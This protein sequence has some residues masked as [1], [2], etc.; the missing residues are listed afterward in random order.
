MLTCVNKNSKEFRDLKEMSGLSEFYIEAYS[1]NYL[2]KLDRFPYLDEIPNAN[3]EPYLQEKLKMKGRFGSVSELLKYTGTSSV[4]DAVIVINN[5]HR[6]LEVRAIQISEDSVIIN[7]DHKPGKYSKDFQ[8]QEKIENNHSSI[9]LD[10]FCDK[11]AFLY[12]INIIP[13]TNVEINQDENLKQIPNIQISKAFIVNNT[14][15]I[16]TDNATIDSK[17]HE[18]MHLLFA[19]MRNIS[20]DLY[21]K[22]IEKAEKFN[23]FDYIARNYPN[24]TQGDLL[25]EIFVTELSRHLAGLESSIDDLSEKEYNEIHYQMTRMLDIAFGGEISSRCIPEDEIYNLTFG[26]IGQRVNSPVTSYK[27]QGSLN[28]TEIHR[29]LANQKSKLLRENKLKEICK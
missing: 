18:L 10:D 9:I 26:Q 3:S 16:N 5:L 4:D 25:E 11:L 8:Q 22:F 6:D 13:I 2:Q 17:V 19:T 23:N 20:P 14:I 21:F 29:I 27:F 15:Y 24:R 7:I 12:G 1:R 28:E